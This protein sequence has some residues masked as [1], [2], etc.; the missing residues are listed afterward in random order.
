MIFLNFQ[1]LNYP[2]IPVTYRV[3][4]NEADHP[5]CPLAGNTSSPGEINLAVPHGVTGIQLMEAAVAVDK[6]FHFTASFDY[7]EFGYHIDSINGILEDATC[8]WGLYYQSYNATP[9]YSSVTISSFYPSFKAIV[10]WI[11]G[12]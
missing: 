8:Y 10:T 12:K 6:K 3:I 4:I 7:A 1:P 2:D 11:Y 5:D 9:V